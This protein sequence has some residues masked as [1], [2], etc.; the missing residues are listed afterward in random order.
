MKGLRH[1]SK[2]ETISVSLDRG[3]TPGTF[4]SFR[5]PIVNWILWYMWFLKLLSGI[6]SSL[7]VGLRWRKCK[8]TRRKRKHFIPNASVRD[9]GRLSRWPG[10]S[11]SSSPRRHIICTSGS[12]T[13]MKFA[14]FALYAADFTNGVRRLRHLVFS[15]LWF[16]WPERAQGYLWT[17]WWHFLDYSFKVC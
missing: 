10:P 14:N 6:R 4:W 1:D 9:V 15:S 7:E 5:V 12:K 8:N 11:G 16:L 17:P 13:P 3:P 2:G